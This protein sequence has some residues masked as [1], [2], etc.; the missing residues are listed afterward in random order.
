MGRQASIAILAEPAKIVE[1]S[2]F[3]VV[4]ARIE[5]EKRIS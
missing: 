4:L 1:L 2:I 5:G 3:N